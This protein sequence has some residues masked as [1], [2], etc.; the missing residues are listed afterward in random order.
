MI[1]ELNSILPNDLS[2]RLSISQHESISKLLG[3]GNLMKNVLTFN[4]G[5]NSKGPIHIDI[6]NLD[7]LN[8]PSTF[9]LNIPITNCN[10][11]LVKWY[12]SDKSILDVPDNDIPDFP[13]T[14]MLENK[15][16]T[17]IE[18]TDCI[19]PH[20]VNIDTWHS[21]TN[22]SKSNTAKLISIRFFENLITKD[23]LVKRFL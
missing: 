17:E 22:N 12:S 16:A 1:D 3:L 23:E 7:T 5:P 21:V 11:L 4:V 20:I 19:V 18:T 2:K 13:N 8:V 15:Y 10:D 9:A 6:N 14:P